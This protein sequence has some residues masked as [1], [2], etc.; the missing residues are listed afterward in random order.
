MLAEKILIETDPRLRD[1]TIAATFR[2]IH[3]DVAFVPLHQQMLA[4]GVSNKVTVVQPATNPIW[5]Y[6]FRKD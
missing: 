2:I 3:E 6:L 5:F 4:W 1:Q